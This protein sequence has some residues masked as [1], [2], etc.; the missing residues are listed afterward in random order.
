MSSGSCTGSLFS[1]TLITSS[2]T[3]RPNSGRSITLNNWIHYCAV[4]CGVL[5]LISIGWVLSATD[6]SAQP[7]DLSGSTFDVDQLPSGYY[8]V[9]KLHFDGLLEA[10]ID[11]N[12][13][14]DSP[15]F[16]FSVIRDGKVI[17]WVDKAE[18]IS[19]LPVARKVD[20]QILVHEQSNGEKGYTLIVSDDQSW[21]IEVPKEYLEKG[22]PHAEH[23]SP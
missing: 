11:P 4:F 15:L 19:V 6:I 8:G 12:I 23:A 20:P 3:R 10:P 14:F 18:P 5:L 16:S 7:S 17:G 9:Q 2:A 1:N 21:L 22:R 13:T